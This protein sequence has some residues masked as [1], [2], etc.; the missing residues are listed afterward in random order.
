MITFAER[1]QQMRHEIRDLK[2]AQQRVFGSMNFY[3]QSVSYTH[4]ASPSYEDSFITITATAAAGEVAP[5]FCQLAFS[6]TEDL[7]ATS[8]TATSTSIKWI[9]YF[10]DVSATDFVFTGIATSNFTITAEQGSH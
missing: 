5:F 4:P 10:N 1:I 8:M 7:V 3:K 2:T 9:F 6:G